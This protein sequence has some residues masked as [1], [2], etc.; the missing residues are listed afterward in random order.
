MIGVKWKEFLCPQ[1]FIL[2]SGVRDKVIG[3]SKKGWR[4]RGSISKRLGEHRDTA[5]AEQTEKP[6][7]TETCGRSRSWGQQLVFLETLPAFGR[8]LGK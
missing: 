3:R 4:R 8:L 1:T 5:A 2:V 6:D 7:T